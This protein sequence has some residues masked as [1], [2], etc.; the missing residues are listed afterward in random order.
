[1]GLALAI[2]EC[3]DRLVLKNFFTSGAL[4]MAAAV[5]TN[6]RLGVHYPIAVRVTESRCIAVNISI[7]TA[8]GVG[9]ITVLCTGRR[10]YNGLVIMSLRC[11]LSSFA[12]VAICTNSNLFA[13]FGAGRN[14]GNRP[15]TERVTGCF[16]VS[17]DITIATSADVGC[18]TLFF[19][20]RSGYDGF[21][22]MNMREGGDDLR[23]F[24]SASVA[25]EGAYSGFLFRRL[26]CDD[27]VVKAMTVG[28]NRGLNYKNLTANVA[29]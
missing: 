29:V 21:I 6:R 13:F 25:G 10:G 20:I 14:A 24:F 12:E 3:L 22:A 17:V 2:G 1:M 28:R 15:S 8:A 26:L 5:N 27:T 16:H 9:G 19:A 18:V 4:D 23:F 11:D 7:P